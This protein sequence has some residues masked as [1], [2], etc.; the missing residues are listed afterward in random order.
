[1][2][3]VDLREDG[4]LCLL[5]IGV[6]QARHNLDVKRINKDAPRE[7]LRASQS[8][9]TD[10]N[11]IK[12]FTS[13]AKEAKN[14]VMLNSVP[15]PIPGMTWIPKE[16]IVRIDK[17]LSEIS[18]RY[19]SLAMELSKGIDKEREKYK[20]KYPEYYDASRYPS[21]KEIMNK[22]YIRWQFFE[23]DLPGKLKLGN[24]KI[25]QKEK[26]K[27]DKIKNEIE[28]MTLNLFGNMIIA[29]LNKLNSQCDSG[30]TNQGTIN[31]INKLLEKWEK[32]WSPHIEEQKFRMA[33]LRIKRDMKRISAEQLKT[34]DD[35]R[36]EIQKR[37]EGVINKIKNVPNFSLYRS[38]D[39]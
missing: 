4:V 38:L 26:E 21:E 31:A 23:V 25:Y 30:K 5:R 22:F 24:A 2:K 35:L 39:I 12:E 36:S 27:A 15:H 16:D 34:N 20:K 33:M 32:L 8:L 18:E 6:W 14:F 3:K 1:M 17:K 11:V 29:R 28:E 7:I 37:T 13:V 10:R 19:S 9:L